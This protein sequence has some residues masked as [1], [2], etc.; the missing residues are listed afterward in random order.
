MLL[1]ENRHLGLRETVA[2]Q[3]EI[4]RPAIRRTAPRVRREL[5]N[6]ANAICCA[7]RKSRKHSSMVVLPVPDLAGERDEALAALH[8]VDQAGQSFFVLRDSGRENEGS[9]LM[10][11]G[12]WVK[13]KKRVVHVHPILAGST[14]RILSAGRITPRWRCR[15]LCTKQR[16][17]SC[18]A[19]AYRSFRASPV[20]VG[21]RASL[22]LTNVFTGLISTCALRPSSARHAFHG[23]IRR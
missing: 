10:L 21:P 19:R 12:F 3:V 5:N 20:S 17:R 1:S 9:G 18:E 22:P 8:A 14:S 15:L 4:S 23:A 7:L 13:P 2:A 16:L 11:N 6:D